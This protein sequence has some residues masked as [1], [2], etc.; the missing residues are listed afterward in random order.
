MAAAAGFLSSPERRDVLQKYIGG[1]LS[2]KEAGEQLGVKADRIYKL[3][4][5]FEN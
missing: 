2:G 5:N 1:E 4:S 3:A